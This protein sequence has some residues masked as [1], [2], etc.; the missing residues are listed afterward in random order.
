MKWWVIYN[1]VQL[2]YECEEIQHPGPGEHGQSD[3]SSSPLWGKHPRE[4]TLQWHHY[5]CLTLPISDLS[6]DPLNTRGMNM[7]CSALIRCEMTWYLPE[8]LRT[9]SSTF[10]QRK[11][12]LASDRADQSATSECPHFYIN[13][14][15][16]F[17]VGLFVIIR[18]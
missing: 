14:C 7:K 18:K 8:Q 11:L 4:I 10:L 17:L 3:L 9:P 6:L 12:R 1:E 13:H 15:L 16:Q 5:L 2:R